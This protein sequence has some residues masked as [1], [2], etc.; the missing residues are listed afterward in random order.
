MEWVSSPSVFA[1]LIF[2][3]VLLLWTFVSQ[4][5]K[6][7]SLPPGPTGVPVLGVLPRL[8]RK[9]YLT[10]QKWWG[11]YGDVFSLY[12]GQRFCI[13]INGV[14]AMKECF[15][16]QSDVFSARPWNFFKKVTK[17]KGQLATLIT[18]NFCTCHWCVLGLVFTD[19]EPW[20]EHRR[21]T[22]SC[23]RDFGMG[24]QPIEMKIQEEAQHLIQ[25]RLHTQ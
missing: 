13:V 16:T 9:P 10:I 24:K 22:L 1:C 12:M 8:R 15:V 18:H 23:L 14:D 11:E 6:R 25:V 2:V 7:R 3:T 4:N 17:N 21:F 5:L 20:R 19:G